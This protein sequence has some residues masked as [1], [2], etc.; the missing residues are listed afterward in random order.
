MDRSHVLSFGVGVAIGAIA[1]VS[2]AQLG[3]P[4]PT[5]AAPAPAA[6][7]LDVQALGSAAR[8]AELASLRARV[9]ELER[10]EAAARTAGS[11]SGSGGE[12]ARAFAEPST[13]SGLSTSDAWWEKMP[14]NPSWDEARRQAIIDRLAKYISVR[15]DKSRVECRTR[16][17]RI[18]VDEETYDAHNDEL[19]SSVGLRYEPP[20]GYGTSHTKDGGIMITT[21]WSTK[22][23]SKPLPD[24]GAERDA[25]LARVA[26]ALRKCGQSLTHTLTLRMVLFLDEEGQISKVESN[27]AQLGHPATTCAETAVLQAAAFSPAPWETDVPVVVKLGKP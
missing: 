5:V 14:R 9:V 21:C 6:S 12:P 25:L 18:A 7:S 4:K 10:A 26:D 15:L 11:A 20:D 16:C 22:P 17:C 1:A 13:E 27:K 3:K 24:R 8:A 2:I 23:P 19:M